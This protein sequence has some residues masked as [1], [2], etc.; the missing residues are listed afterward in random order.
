[1]A[2]TQTRAMGLT[3][4]FSAVFALAGCEFNEGVLG[5]GGTALK[6]ATLS[7]DDVVQLSNQSCQAMD[8]DNRVAAQNSP[9]ATRLARVIAPFPTEMDGQP[10]QYKVYLTK[11]LNAW[12]MGNGCVRVYSGLMDLMNDDELRGVIGHELGHVAMGHSVSRMRTTYALNAARQVAAA[13]GNATAAMLSQSAAGDLGEAFIGAQFSQSQEHA[14]DNYSFDL[15]TQLQ[16]ERQGLVTGFQKL[17]SQ[18]AQSSALE[19]LL[20]SHPASESRVRNMQNRLNQ[21]K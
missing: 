15:L 12:A 9:Y 3:V 18:S 14:A 13:S 2:T 4:A 11:D 7:K 8:A 19:S 17:G 16:L 6:A 20:S 10:I 21:S 1:M 5:A